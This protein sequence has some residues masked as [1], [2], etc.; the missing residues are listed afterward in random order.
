M[1]HGMNNNRS[2]NSI[3]KGC[4]SNSILLK[5]LSGDAFYSKLQYTE[6]DKG[7]YLQSSYDTHVYLII[8]P[9]Q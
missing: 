5:Q 6:K 1:P 8:P 9:N 7:S 2:S 3:D 4:S